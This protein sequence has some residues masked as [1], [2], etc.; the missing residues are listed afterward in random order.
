MQHKSNKSR[1]KKRAL[2]HP[3]NNTNDEDKTQRNE[4][5][6]SLKVTSLKVS[7]KVSRITTTANAHHKTTNASQDYEFHTME[8]SF[9]RSCIY[10]L[11][12]VQ[13]HHSIS[14]TNNCVEMVLSTNRSV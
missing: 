12:T 1:G 2:S 3:S 8:K 13:R 14:V 10:L 6:T 7:A 5:S 4:T 11:D 9:K